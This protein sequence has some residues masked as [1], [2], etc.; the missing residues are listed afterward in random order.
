VAPEGAGAVEAALDGER[1]KVSKTVETLRQL[2]T[3]LKT[4][5]RYHP[6]ATWCFPV[7]APPQVEAARDGWGRSILYSPLAPDSTQK[8]HQGF[9]LT[10]YGGDGVPTKGN[11]QSPAADIICRVVSG[12]ESWQQPNEFWRTQEGG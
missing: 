11:L 3:S 5:A 2:C 4:D 6:G 8:C 1:N 7:T 9:A 10:S 12:G